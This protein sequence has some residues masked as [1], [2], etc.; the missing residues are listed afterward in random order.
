MMQC[1]V[2]FKFRYEINEYGECVK[3]TA[4]TDKRK[5]VIL[6][7]KRRGRTEMAPFLH[8]HKIMSKERW[9]SL[10]ALID[11]FYNNTSMEEIEDYNANVDSARS[12]ALESSKPVDR[13]VIYLLQSNVGYY[14]IG[15]SMN[16]DR[17]VGQHLRNYP[18]SLDV[19]HVVPVLRM[20]RCE[21][22]LLSLFAEKKM[23]GEWFLLSDDDV[24]WI[25]SLDT[26]ALES[27]VE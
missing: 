17:R 15:K 7:V 26:F 10:R 4:V 21:L 22:Y 19:I 12:A 9:L 13:G 6:H 2:C 14:K 18:V 24:A 16:L 3:C 1:K 25:C 11:K 27:L 23:Q 5:D 8:N 20:T